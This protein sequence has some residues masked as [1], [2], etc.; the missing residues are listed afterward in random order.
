MIPVD[1]PTVKKVL[2]T[3]Q[4]P[5]ASVSWKKV[6]LSLNK[7]PCPVLW[8]PLLLFGEFR[9]KAILLQAVNS[10]CFEKSIVFL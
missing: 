6:F 2:F 5:E 8:P 1:A 3:M 9:Q 10:D 4:V 7:S